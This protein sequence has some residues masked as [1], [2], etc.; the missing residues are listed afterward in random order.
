MQENSREAGPDNQSA[1]NELLYV[2]AGWRKGEPLVVGT[3]EYYGK[4]TWFIEQVPYITFRRECK[5]DHVGMKWFYSFNEFSNFLQ[6][7][8]KNI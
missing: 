5:P 2:P 1:S 6:W 8:H 7:W 4:H 3:R